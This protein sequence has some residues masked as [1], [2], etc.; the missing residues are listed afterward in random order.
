MKRWIV[1]VKTKQDKQHN[2]HDKKRGPCLFSDDC[3]D[4]TGAHH[5]FIVLAQT[6]KEVKD[7]VKRVYG[8]IHI[9]RI[10]LANIYDSTIMQSR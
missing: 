2:P 3:T 5:S 10:E 1:T 7:V 8:D 9:T 6:V 4:V